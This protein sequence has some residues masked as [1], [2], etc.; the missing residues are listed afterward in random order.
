MNL[1]LTQQLTLAP[2]L[3]VKLKLTPAMRQ[4]LH[5]LQL[6][7][8]DLKLYLENELLTNPVLEE[9][10]PA[11]ETE[12]MNSPDSLE[13]ESLLEKTLASREVSLQEYLMHQL[14]LLKIPETEMS[15]AWEIVGN[16]DEDGYLRLSLDEVA[17]SC[18][19][20][21]EETAGVLSR[22]QKLDP[23][24]VA[25]RSL[26]ECLLI[27]LRAKSA[28]FDTNGSLAARMVQ[29]HLAELKTKK[30]GKIAGDLGVSLPEV[31]SAAAEIKKLDPKPARR[32]SQ[33][34]PFLII[35]DVRIYRKRGRYEVEENGGEWPSLTISPFYRRLL[36]RTDTPAEAK[37]YIREK[38]SAGLSL[39][40]ALKD[41]GR[42][43]ERVARLIT[44]EQTEFLE[45]GAA[46]LRPM[47]LEQAASRL[48][49]HK[50][51]LSRAVVNKYVDTP[52]G[53]FEFKTFFKQPACRENGLHSGEALKSR[54][55]KL[56][57][58]ENSRKPFS[59]KQLADLLVKQGIPIAR[60]T[61]AKY[62]EELRILPSYLRK[63]S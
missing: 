2:R 9:D 30:Y 10:E 48:G 20:S 38:L 19:A 55:Q 37:K 16:L 41:R 57:Q 17:A 24:G 47:T 27:Q 29:H 6:P 21:P 62:R 3:E 45:K 15:I 11:L 60:R 53:I 46:H 26:G 33:T 13:E 40:K 58:N 34:K 63:T 8:M 59:D 12:S 1:S 50:S 25:A 44:S 32:F 23:P 7:L 28:S 42:T 56:I 31:L 35:P 54:V 49:F 22:V 43:L 51:T 4:S 61:I 36:K 14:R 39:M 52:Q 5:L 18:S